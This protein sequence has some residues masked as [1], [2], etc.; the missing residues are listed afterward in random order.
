M[1]KRIP[2]TGRDLNM[3]IGGNL[4]SKIDIIKDKVT[5]VKALDINMKQKKQKHLLFNLKYLI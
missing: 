5:H 3:Q 1:T 2:G 4:I